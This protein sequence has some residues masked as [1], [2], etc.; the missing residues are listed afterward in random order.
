MDPLV[1]A[2]LFVRRA[3]RRASGLVLCAL[4]ATFVVLGGT[5]AP[6]VALVPALVLWTA[7]T[8]SRVVRKL[9]KKWLADAD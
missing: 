7:L 4:L 1:R 9:R 3:S 2:A 6:L 8:L 5:N